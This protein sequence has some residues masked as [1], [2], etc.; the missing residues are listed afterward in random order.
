MSK[1]DIKGLSLEELLSYKKDLNKTYERLEFEIENFTKAYKSVNEELKMR[2]DEI[3]LELD[4]L[5]AN[6]DRNLIEPDDMQR[7]LEKL[8]R[9]DINIH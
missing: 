2:K 4:L 5:Q 7:V 8:E 9:D 1:K 6:N 3:L